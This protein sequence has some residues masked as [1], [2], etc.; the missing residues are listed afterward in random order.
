MAL[1]SHESLDMA[2]TL[3]TRRMHDFL[4]QELGLDP[5][6]AAMLLSVEG[7]LRICQVVDP[8][9]TVRMELPLAILR[10]AGC[11]LA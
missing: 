6:A 8:R 10:E 2:A 11:D 4:V 1:A 3:A 9:K 5:T 7:N